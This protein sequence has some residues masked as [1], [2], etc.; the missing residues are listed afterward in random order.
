MGLAPLR[1]RSPVRS[2][3]AASHVGAGN[4]A[5]RNGRAVHLPLPPPQYVMVIFRSSA[6]TAAPSERRSW[7]SIF[8]RSGVSTA[9][10]TSR[11]LA[12]GVEQTGYLL[13]G[14]DQPT[15][16]IGVLGY[17]QMSPIARQRTFMLGLVA[18]RVKRREGDPEQLAD[19]SARVIPAALAG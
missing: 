11:A 18:W 9:S 17:R 7:P 5:S 12:I 8:A 4:S 13:A 2:P 6:E 1:Y 15:E 16:Q 3:Q 10:T 14:I 19:E